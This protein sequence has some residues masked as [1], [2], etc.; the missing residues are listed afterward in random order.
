[1]STPQT[2][3]A[4]EHRDF[5]RCQVPTGYCEVRIKT[6]PSKT[7]EHVGHCYDLSASGMRF[8]LDK[9]LAC[10]E[11]VQM[12]LTLNNPWQYTLTGRGQVVRYHDPG[13]TG[14]VRMGMNFIEFDD[15]YARLL[16]DWYV[17][18]HLD[19]PHSQAA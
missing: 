8:E 6:G 18:E 7:C 10:G 16:I 19:R 11:E 2:S 13:E 14:P 5:S 12:Q 1:M 9:P 4:D 15:P 17:H 3:G